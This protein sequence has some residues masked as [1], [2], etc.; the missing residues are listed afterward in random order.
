MT[1]GNTASRV[2]HSRQPARHKAKFVLGTLALLVV[3]AVWGWRPLISQAD[4]GTAFGARTACSCRFVTGRDLG[5]CKKD[6]AD[7]MALVS[8]S[9][10][11]AGK[12]VTARVPLISSTTAT[13]R[14]G[15][16]C[17]LDPYD[18]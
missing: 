14:E 18:G 7:G 4:A 3:V 11:E 5:D 15:R 6:F 12:S 9:E 2:P 8:L 1:T 10:D 13:L 17:V 16:G